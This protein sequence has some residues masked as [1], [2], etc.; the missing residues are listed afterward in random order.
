MDK[1]SLFYNFKGRWVHI[2]KL[3][4]IEDDHRLFENFDVDFLSFSH[5]LKLY[6]EDF[7]MPNVKK[8]CY[9]ML[10]VLIENAELIVL[11]NDEGIKIL[12]DLIKSFKNDEVLRV[13][14]FEEAYVTPDIGI[15]NAPEGCIGSSS[16]DNVQEGGIGCSFSERFKKEVLVVVFL[17]MLQKLLKMIFWQLRSWITSSTSI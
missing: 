11:E 12:T 17:K 3:S 1:V 10:G 7:G 15:K 13:Y 5:M 9:V 2:P 4:Y 6:K 14:P 16:V 8:L